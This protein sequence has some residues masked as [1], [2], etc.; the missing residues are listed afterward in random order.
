MFKYYKNEDKTSFEGVID[1]DLITCI[2]Q[3]ED[4]PHPNMFK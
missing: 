2:I 4:K 1:L 3:V